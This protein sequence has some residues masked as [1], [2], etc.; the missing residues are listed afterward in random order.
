MQTI[1]KSLPRSGL[2]TSIVEGKL[3]SEG[4]KITQW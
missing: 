4:N 1:I 2:S 3:M